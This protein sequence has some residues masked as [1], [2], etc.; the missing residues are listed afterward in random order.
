MNDKKN[1][2][3][4]IDELLDTPLVLDKVN[5]PAFFK[6]KVLNKLSQSSTEKSAT[7]WLF[8]FTP[9]YQI[10]AMVLFVM[11]NLIALYN[12][13]ASNKEVELQNYAQAYG[14]SNTIQDSI[15]N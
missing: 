5:T 4:F 11:L 2:S 9:K 14:L 3:K 10:A 12:Y 6:D 8:W 1:T 13:S 15:L 7:D